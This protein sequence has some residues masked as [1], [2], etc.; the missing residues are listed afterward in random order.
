MIHNI[1]FDQLSVGMEAT[2]IR[3]VTARDVELFAYLSGDFNPL[4]LDEAYASTTP[5]GGRIAH[6]AFCAMLIS[7]AVA[8]HLPG[9]GSIY[10]GQEMRFRQPVRIGDELTVTLSLQEKK[11]RGEIVLIANRIVNQTGTTV[12][13]GVS[14]VRAPTAALAIEPA[15]V[16]AEQL[17]IAPNR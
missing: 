1:P 8:N 7:A 3:Q 4:H 11:R 16:T 2:L 13:T 9:P 10:L 15:T 5:F 6:G 12:F 14:T 17:V